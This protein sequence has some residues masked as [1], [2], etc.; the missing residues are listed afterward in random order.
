MVHHRT[1]ATIDGVATSGQFREVRTEI[2]VG[3]NPSSW[4]PMDRKTTPVLNSAI[5]S[6]NTLGVDDGAYT[7]RVT[8]SDAVFGDA[9]TQMTVVVSNKPTATPTPRP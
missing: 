6:W 9:V 3:L 4:I 8:L 7:L 1:A 5:A 2:G